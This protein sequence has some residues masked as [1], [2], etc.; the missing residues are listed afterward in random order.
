M[1]VF[2][3]ITRIYRNLQ[4]LQEFTGIYSNLQEFSDQHFIQNSFDKQNIVYHHQRFHFWCYWQFTGI[5]RI[6]MNLHEFTGI[7][8]NF[9]IKTSYKIFLTTKI[10]FTITRGSIFDVF[11]VIGVVSASQLKIEWLWGLP[12]NYFGESPNQ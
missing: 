4:E 6:Y 8:K 10:L 5:T 12:L 3:G 9:L 7:Y 11:E 1:R 2:T